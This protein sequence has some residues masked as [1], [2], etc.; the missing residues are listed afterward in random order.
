MSSNLTRIYFTKSLH[1]YFRP[2]KF[3]NMNISTDWSLQEIKNI[4]NQPLLDLIYQAATAHREN[5]AYAKVQT[6][7]LISIK[8]GGC[9]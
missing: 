5:K 9:K 7:N 2:A 8:T 1:C 6:S 4:Y 3:K